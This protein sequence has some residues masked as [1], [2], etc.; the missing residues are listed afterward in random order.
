MAFSQKSG[1]PS[2]SESVALVPVAMVPYPLLESPVCV[3][4]V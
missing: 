1:I 2:L 3:W 4:L